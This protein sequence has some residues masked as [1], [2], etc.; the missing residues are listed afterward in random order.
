MHAHI[1]ACTDGFALRVTSQ[2]PNST[3]IMMKGT[4]HILLWQI[5]YMTSF[6]LAH[7]CRLVHPP[8]IISRE[9]YLPVFQ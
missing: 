7:T 2:V 3:T 8:P 5:D 9:K 1:T 4:G 6:L